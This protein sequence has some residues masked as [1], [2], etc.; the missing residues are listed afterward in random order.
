MIECI[1]DSFASEYIDSNNKIEVKKGE[2]FKLLYKNLK[3]NYQIKR[4]NNNDNKYWYV[5]KN[6]FKI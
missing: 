3:N 2:Q 4:L 1:S 6:N 5:Q